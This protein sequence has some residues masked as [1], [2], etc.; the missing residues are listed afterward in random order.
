MLR[1]EKA[2]GE[3]LPP[4][5]DQRGITERNSLVRRFFGS[6]TSMQAIQKGFWSKSSQLATRTRN[7]WRVTLENRR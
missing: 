5:D 7:P 6:S 2:S 1:G 4:D 3:S